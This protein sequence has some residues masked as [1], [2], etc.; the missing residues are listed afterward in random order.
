MTLFG[1]FGIGPS[2]KKRDL[3]QPAVLHGK[4]QERCAYLDAEDR[5]VGFFPGIRRDD[6][7]IVLCFFHLTTCK[8]AR[9]RTARKWSMVQRRITVSSSTCHCSLVCRGKD[10]F[11]R[12]KEVIEIMRVG[13]GNE[14]AL[15]DFVLKLFLR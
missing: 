5:Y 2:V 7:L 12:L 14:L 13:E 4:R 9:R 6:P 8:R 10:L 15:L 3:D 11:K 1:N